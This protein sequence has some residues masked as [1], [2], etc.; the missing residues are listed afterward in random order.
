MGAVAGER[1]SLAL[2]PDAEDTDSRRCLRRED[3][4]AIAAVIAPWDGAP[5]AVRPSSGGPSYCVEPYGRGWKLAART[6]DSGDVLLWYTGRLVRSGG[7]LLVAPDREY[8]VRSKPLRRLD[9]HVR[10][11]DGRPLLSVEAHP[12]SRYGAEIGLVMH[13]RPSH[14]ADSELLVT[15]LAVLALLVHRSGAIQRSFGIDGAP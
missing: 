15:F 4:S 6:E 10:D 9:L 1:L 7:T 13:D 3:G 2:D 5:P 8:D 12:R 11:P 14:E